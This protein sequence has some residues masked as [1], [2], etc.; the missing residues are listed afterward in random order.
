[1][2]TKETP[3]RLEHEADRALEAMALWAESGQAILRQ[4]AEFAVKAVEEGT[5]LFA[6]FQ[7]AGFEAAKDGQAWTQ[8]VIREGLEESRRVVTHFS[9]SGTA[10]ARAAQGLQTAGDQAA[11]K[12]R[13]ALGEAAARV[14]DLY[15]PAKP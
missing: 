8:R 2:K 7:A 1:M 4:G 6:A 3:D 10:A 13:A 9:E 12:M 14:N 15:T 5:R 11:I